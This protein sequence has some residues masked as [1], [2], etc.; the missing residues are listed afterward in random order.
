MFDPESN[1][2]S[3]TPKKQP[4]WWSNLYEHGKTKCWWDNAFE[5]MATAMEEEESIWGNSLDDID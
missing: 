5:A 4:D 1:N 2:V 3:G